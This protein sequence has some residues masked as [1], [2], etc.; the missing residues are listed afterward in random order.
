MNVLDIDTFWSSV[1]ESRL[2]ETSRLEQLRRSS[3]TQDTVAVAKWLVSQGVLSTWQARRLVRGD[4]GPFFVGNFRLMKR[5]DAE[6]SGLLFR[7]REE[8]TGKWFQLRP[9]EG[10]LCKNQEIWSGIVRQT[11]IAKAVQSPL[12]SKTFTVSNV[13]SQRFIVCEDIPLTTLAEELSLH[14]KFTPES[15]LKVAL[16]VTKGV[17]EIHR[18]GGVHGA[19]SLHALRQASQED[20]AASRE[21]G[22]R[23]AQFPLAGDPHLQPPRLPL[24]QK[25]QI[26]ALGHR[27]C[28]LAPELTDSSSCC[29]PQS[30][31][32]A[33]GCLVHSLILG[34]AI[35]WRGSPR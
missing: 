13:R 17:A 22:I 4:R 21:A 31:V 9:L 26:D 28:F 34:S 2:I 10:T 3:K 35:G 30:D 12:L 24:E 7:V 19:I 27:A 5:L 33:I 32:Y 6:G 18:H 23:L 15:C 1:A 29:T 14:G 11:K 16:E 8:G 25:E 20:G